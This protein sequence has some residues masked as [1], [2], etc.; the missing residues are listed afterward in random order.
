M[1]NRLLPNGD[2]S[3]TLI[4][5]V[6]CI[7]R[8]P[9]TSSQEGTKPASAG[10]SFG[11]LV[12]LHWSTDYRLLYRLTGNTHDT[13]DLTQETFLRAMKR[14]A[15]LRP[16]SNLRAW[17]LRIASNAFFDVQR[18]R[19][20]VKVQELEA[21]P[22]DMRKPAESPI[23]TAE[24]RD[25][26]AAEIAELPEKARVVFLLRAREGLSFREIAE[27]VETSEETARWHMLQAR[28]ILLA[29]LNGKL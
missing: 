29:R 14:M 11:E 12:D 1:E 23:E 10:A 8:K 27:I 26:L 20:T 16:D 21:E 18:K 7:V 24:L 15:S 9:K 28:K 17:L 5:L 6:R 13:E 19:Q 3:G 22:P 2:E 25:L 4:L